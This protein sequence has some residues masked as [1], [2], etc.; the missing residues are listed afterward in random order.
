MFGEGMF[1]KDS[2]AIEEWSL[3]NVQMCAKR[4][5]I[6]LSCADAMLKPNG[7]MVYSTYIC[8]SRR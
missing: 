3:E 6:I 2:T 8:S 4:Q 5:K 7:I 1:R